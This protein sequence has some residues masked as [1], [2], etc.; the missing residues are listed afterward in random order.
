MKRKAVKTKVQTGLLPGFDNMDIFVPLGVLLSMGFLMQRLTGS[1]LIQMLSAVV[2][3]VLS[4]YARMWIKDNLAPKHI[5][6]WFN[7]ILSSDVLIPEP[8][9]DPIPLVIAMPERPS[10][11]AMD[12]LNARPAAQEVS[13]VRI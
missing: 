7:W 4:F 1:A 8:D 5:P 3:A 10:S 9:P 11:R 2:A 6:H 12:G 13:R